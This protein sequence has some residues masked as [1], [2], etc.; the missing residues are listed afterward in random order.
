MEIVK[1]LG[2][3]VMAV[4]GSTLLSQFKPEYSLFVQLTAVAVIA[5]ICMDSVTDIFV[6]TSNLTANVQINNEYISLLFKALAI[7]VG[8]KI[9]GDVCADNGNRAVA[10]CVDFA[11]KVAI[12]LLCFPLIT[13]LA[14]ITTDL[15]KI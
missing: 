8:G 2:I 9:V 5:L 12:V 11:C 13:A 4:I 1:I 15:I 6:Q 10:T 3:A 14:Q 7:V